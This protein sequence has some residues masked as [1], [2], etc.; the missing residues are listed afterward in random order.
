MTDTQTQK[1]GIQVKICGIT[2][3]EDA[4]ACVATGANAVGFIFY[5]KSPRHV[6]D[7][8]AARIIEQVPETVA[9]VGVFVNADYDTLIRK[10]RYCGLSAVQLH[11]QESPDLVAALANEHITVIKTLF[12]KTAPAFDRIKDY[13][14]AAFLVE[15]GKGI[16]PGGNAMQWDWGRA[17]RLPRTRPLI[18]AGGLSAD[19]VA[20]AVGLALPDAVDISS[21]VELSPGIKD[22]TKIR[23][24]IR[25]I[26]ESPTVCSVF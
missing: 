15:C 16:L 3:V 6:S 19:N 10:V 9:R 5:P 20:E 4:L 11:G 25:N 26:P 21:A 22:A 1:K 14:P 12:E 8:T 24:F 2:R 13:D 17:A 18:L 23:A 7:D